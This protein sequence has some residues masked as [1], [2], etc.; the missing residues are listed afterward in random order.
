MSNSPYPNQGLKAWID[1]STYC[2]AACPQC[3]RTEAQGLTKQAWLPLIQWSL[4]D[5]KRKFPP[6]S[7]KYYDQFEF[8]GTWGDPLMCK[9][10][11]KIV[12]YVLSTD[13]GVK[14]QLNTNGSL[15]NPDWWWNFGVMGGDRLEVIFDIDGIDQAMHERYRQNTDLNLI[16]DNVESFCTTPARAA[17]ST[18]VFRHNENYVDDIEKMIRDWGVTG[19]HF[20]IESNRFYHGPSFSFASANGH[21]ILLEQTTQ[22]NNS[23]H[24][25]PV[26]DHRWRKKF[27]ASGRTNNAL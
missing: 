22:D 5:F 19:G 20:P 2:N 7:I 21:R 23:F 15:R 1:L 9:D 12:E 10:I 17:V 6:E 16:K 18:I 24:N 14:V 13:L 26:K 4:A 27:D 3:H 8:C 11:F 25:Y